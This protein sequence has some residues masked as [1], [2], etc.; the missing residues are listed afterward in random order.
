MGRSICFLIIYAKSGGR[1]GIQTFRDLQSDAGD[2]VKRRQEASDDDD[3]EDED[4]SKDPANFYTGG[5]RSGLNVQNPNHGKKSKAP[6]VVKDILEKAAQRGPAAQAG[7]SGGDAASSVPS[8]QGVG[9]TINDEAQSAAAVGTPPSQVNSEYMRSLR[10]APIDSESLRALRNRQLGSEDNEDD[11]DDEGEVAVR[12][13]TF[14]QDGFTIADGPLCRYD[15]PQH[16]Q[17][18]AM[19][20]NE[21]APLH[22]LNIRFG[23]RVNLHVEKRT[24]EKYKA[25]PPPPMKAFSGS[26]N[27]LGAPV[28]T[29]TGQGSLSAPRPATVPTPTAS[30]PGGS[31]SSA[32]QVDASQPV[33]QIQIRLGDG[34]RVVAKFNQTHTVADIRQYINDSQPGAAQRDYTIQSSFPPKPLTDETQTLKEAGLINSVVIQKWS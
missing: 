15:D 18:L 34:Q 12:N 7:S 4:E 16:A 33:T 20:K 31:S 6:D 11:D 30:T 24:S 21:Q 14:W 3:D 32:V 10:N 9:R 26:G 25:P 8:F 19:I 29:L 13:I 22:L 1:G 5:E 2:S 28:P 17:T 27:R 23:Q